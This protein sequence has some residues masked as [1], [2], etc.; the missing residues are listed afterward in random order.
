M[1]K[2]LDPHPQNAEYLN[3]FSISKL[4][5]EFTMKSYEQ[6]EKLGRKSAGIESDGIKLVF[7]FLFYMGYINFKKERAVVPN[8]ESR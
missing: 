5:K 6:L 1:D 4:E 7:S 3:V 2:L 8:E